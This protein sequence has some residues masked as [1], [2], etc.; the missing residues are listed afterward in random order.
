M[1]SFSSTEWWHVNKCAKTSNCR[2][3]VRILRE[4]MF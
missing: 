4:N 2:G 1:N 3:T